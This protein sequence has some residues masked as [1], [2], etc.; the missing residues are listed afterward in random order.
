MTGACAVNGKH[1][2]MRLFVFSGNR[3]PQVKIACAECE[4]DIDIEDLDE[5]SVE[6]VAEAVLDYHQTGAMNPTQ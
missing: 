1:K 2:G 3:F 6:K 4:E 5:A